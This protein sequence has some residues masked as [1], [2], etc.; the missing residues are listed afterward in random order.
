MKLK[1]PILLSFLLLLSLPVQ[2][3]SWSK[4]VKD[5]NANVQIELPND[6]IGSYAKIEIK[7]LDA[8]KFASGKD[9]YI[10]RAIDF[11][12]SDSNRETAA[13]KPLRTVFLF[14]I[15]DYKRATGSNT[16]KSVGHF[17]VGWWHEDTKSWEELPSQ[18]FW[19]GKKGAVEADISY[20]G[21]YALLWSNSTT[22]LSPVGP[23]KIRIMINNALVNSAE[24][25]YVKEGSTMVPLRV[26]AES[27][28]LEVDW[29]ATERRID[30]IKYPEHIQLWVDDTKAMVNKKESTLAR[31]AEISRNKTFVP[32]RFVAEALGAEVNWDST[33][34]T[35]Y[36]QKNN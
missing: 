24:N 35:V 32:I 12:I 15:F 8:S 23:Q 10:S 9:F 34:K 11:H 25:P 36:I 4:M 21:E 6:A 17:R 13:L 18:V 28:G 20:G 7:K 22:N 29:N 19:D 2:A 5:E 16:T 31:P 30:L 14:D 3:A 27:L 33:R 26:V 1:F